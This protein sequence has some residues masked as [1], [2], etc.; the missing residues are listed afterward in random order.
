M[1]KFCLPLIL[2]LLF[3]GIPALAQRDDL[4][5]AEEAFSKGDYQKSIDLYE[6][7]VKADPRAASSWE[8]LGL[9]YQASGKYSLAVSAFERALKEGF[10]PGNGKYNLA[11]AYARMGRKDDSIRL[12]TELVDQRLTVASQM[13]SDSDFEG[14]HNDSRF[15]SLADQAKLAVE[16]CRDAKNHPEFRELDFW[17]GEWEVFSG[18]QKVGDSSVQLILKSCVIFENWTS[19]TGASGKSFNKYDPANKYWQQYWV[20]DNG[21]TTVFTGHL[22]DGKM[23]YH[24]EQPTAN[25]GT[26]LQNLTFSKL[27]P[28]KVRQFQ[29][30][31]TDGGKTWRTG[32]DFLYVRKK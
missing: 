18:N 16:P 11:C 12:L 22:E 7:I 28:D 25:G 31:S 13:A 3:S 2:A 1:R 32:Y 6:V 24:A 23:R 21:S 17:A 26:L 19:I 14:L 20:A 29:Q 4:K 15:A 5:Q 30:N 9:S 10:A 8:Q 27:S